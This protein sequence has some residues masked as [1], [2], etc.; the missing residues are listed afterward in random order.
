MF[1]GPRLRGRGIAKG[2]MCTQ[3][4]VRCRPLAHSMKGSLELHPEGIPAAGLG[5]CGMKGWGQNEGIES[6][7]GGGG[8][9]REAVM[10]LPSGGNKAIQ[11]AGR[12]GT[13]PPGRPRDRRLPLLS[14]SL[15]REPPHGLATGNRHKRNLTLISD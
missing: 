5:V 4:T 14:A 13:C 1:K 2:Q 12:L 9:R 10:P 8:A 6:L 11:A 7:S 3:V 15:T